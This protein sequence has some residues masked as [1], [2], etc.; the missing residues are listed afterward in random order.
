MGISRKLFKLESY[1]LGKLVDFA[2]LG[3]FVQA[4]ISVGVSASDALFLSKLGAQNLPSI[5]LLTPLV[6][7]AYIPIYSYLINRLGINKVFNLTL[8]VLALGGIFIYAIFRFGSPEVELVAL[9]VA[10][11]YSF[12]WYIALYSLYWNFIDGYFDILDAKRVFAALSAGSALGA[13]LGGGLVS[14]LS[15]NF[16]AH[17]LFLAWSLIAFLTFP[18]LRQCSRKWNVIDAEELDTDAHTSGVVA[19]MKSLL[20]TFK[21]STFA[22][23]LGGLLFSTMIATL[24]CE[25]QFSNILAQNRSEAELAGLFRKLFLVVHSFNLLINLFVFNRLALNLGVRNVTLIQP[26]IYV[27]AFCLMLIDGSLSAGIFG[28][29]AFHGVLTSIDF[30]NTNLLINALP[31]EK[32]RQL[33]TFIEGICEPMANAVAGGLLFFLVTTITPNQISTLGIGV[34][35]VCFALAWALR[36]AYVSSMV[37]NLKSSWLDF[38]AAQPQAELLHYDLGAISDALMKSCSI[39]PR[40]RHLLEASLV[41][42]GAASIPICVKTLKCEDLSLAARSIAARALARLSTQQFDSVSSGVVASE[43]LR[44]SRYAENAAVFEAALRTSLGQVVLAKYCA[45]QKRKIVD[46][47]L[48]LL[49]LNGRLASIELLLASVRSSNPKERADAIE[50]IQQACDLRTNRL[51]LPLLT[52]NHANIGSKVV[53]KQE[54]FSKQLLF[55]RLSQACASSNQIESAS[56]AEA[57]MQLG[58]EIEKVDQT[59]DLLRHKLRQI[60]HANSDAPIVVETIVSALLGAEQEASSFSLVKKI[61]LLQQS[62]FL[63]G[64]GSDHLTA[65]AEQSSVKRYLS[66]ATID[67]SHEAALILVL[68]G[69]VVGTDASRYQAYTLLGQELIY[70]QENSSASVV[71]TKDLCAILIPFEVVVSRACADS[72]LSRYLLQNRF[73]REISGETSANSALQLYDISEVVSA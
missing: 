39:A 57:L 71:V 48:E 10:K 67:I 11:L 15:A 56:A 45:D 44:A 64:F 28:F 4:G 7:L 41:K 52:T 19:E 18:I 33:R 30:N 40:E 29:F 1:E 13:A 53:A 17:E 61:A 22:V 47:V 14:I 21:T 9:Y 24:I 37:E 58:P 12:L 38:S 46:F 35:I 6:F 23:L 8:A 3:A 69:E 68:S 65:I 42:H 62:E 73:N 16:Q 63:E 66:G 43:I 54:P 70:N 2:L 50:T 32:R 59:I 25:Y 51:L 31:K 27:V 36:G 60:S 49:A 20:T 34:A 55:D 26:V 72:E 5:Y